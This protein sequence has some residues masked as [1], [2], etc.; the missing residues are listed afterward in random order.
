MKTREHLQNYERPLPTNR[1]KRAPGAPSRSLFIQFTFG[2]KP[3]VRPSRAEGSC[4]IS[5]NSGPPRRG[6]QWAR[7]AHSRIS[8]WAGPALC[9]GDTAKAETAYQD[10]LSRSKNA[11]AN[12][13]TLKKPRA[14]TRA[15]SKTLYPNR[16][17]ADVSIG[18]FLGRF[19]VL[20]YFAF[21]NSCI[22]LRPC[23]RSCR[24]SCALSDGQDVPPSDGARATSVP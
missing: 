9:R 7:S 13:R 5:E 8:A 2:Q 20:G 14:N 23:R 22:R 11:D 12:L 15:C 19:P 6:D 17:K 10:F 3:F 24:P 16:K 21:S 1:D 4:G 18:L